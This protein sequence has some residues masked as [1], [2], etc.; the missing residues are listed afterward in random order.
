MTDSTTVLVR[1]V[2]NL[3]LDYMKNYEQYFLN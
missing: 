2:S 3:I 1:T